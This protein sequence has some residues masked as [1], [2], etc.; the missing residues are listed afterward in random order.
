MGYVACFVQRFFTQAI[1][2]LN[3]FLLSLIIKNIN[4]QKVGGNGGQAPLAPPGSYS[5]EVDEQAAMP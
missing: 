3:Y 1:V 4:S 5:P 2:N